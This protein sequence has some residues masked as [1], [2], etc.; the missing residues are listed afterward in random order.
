MKISGSN[1]EIA[2]LKND[3]LDR[4]CKVGLQINRLET[5]IKE[6]QFFNQSEASINRVL[7]CFT[8]QK[9]LIDE[10]LDSGACDQTNLQTEQTLHGHEDY[11]VLDES[12]KREEQ[13]YSSENVCLTRLT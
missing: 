3:E 6:E 2:G 11:S 1:T 10:Q 4:I 9:T 7:P 8:N 12:L 5:D 13:N